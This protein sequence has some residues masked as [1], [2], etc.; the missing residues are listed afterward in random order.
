LFAAASMAAQS[1]VPVSYLPS[2]LSFSHCS[3]AVKGA[4][5]ATGSVVGAEVV[6]VHAAS[7]LR[8]KMITAT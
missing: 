4:S 3:W 8:T 2:R 6:C 7:M 5:V 1:W